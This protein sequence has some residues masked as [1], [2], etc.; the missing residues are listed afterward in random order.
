MNL[1]VM[2]WLFFDNLIVYPQLSEFMYPSSPRFS[3]IFFWISE[4]VATL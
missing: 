4:S 2:P 1:I 3:R